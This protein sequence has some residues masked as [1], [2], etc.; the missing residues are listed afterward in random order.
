ML[1]DMMI[2]IN[3]HVCDHVDC[4]FEVEETDNSIMG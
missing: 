3:T 2:L 1:H 4:K